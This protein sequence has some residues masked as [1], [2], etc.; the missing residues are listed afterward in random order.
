MG[1]SYFVLYIVAAALAVLIGI[2]AAT[3]MVVAA[4]KGDWNP[5]P[6]PLERMG[7]VIVSDD[8][9]FVASWYDGRVYKFSF[10]GHLIGRSDGHDTPTRLT[11]RDGFVVV[12]S[13]SRERTL[14]DPAFRIRD[15]GG[16]MAEVERTWWGHPLL[17]VRRADGTT[18]R[19]PLQPW[20]LTMI[21]TPYPGM[22]WFFIMVGLVAVAMWARRRLRLQ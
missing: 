1:R 3:T 22:L 14:E 20:Y 17:L 12:R 16:V 9:V 8:S 6:R 5:L 19:A 11:R 4:F 7:G 18:T 2:P 10:D 21:Q 13:G 15:P